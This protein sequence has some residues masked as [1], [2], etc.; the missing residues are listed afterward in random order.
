MYLHVSILSVTLL[1][2]LGLVKKGEICCW[3]ARVLVS[4]HELLVCV[5]SDVDKTLDGWMNYYRSLQ[6]N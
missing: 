2:D 4:L 6:H 5:K 1:S 3:I